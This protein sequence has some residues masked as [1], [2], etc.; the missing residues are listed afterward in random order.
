MVVI[1]EVKPR[2]DFGRRGHRVAG[3]A[4]PQGGVGLAANPTTGHF[5]VSNSAADSLTIFD[6]ASLAELA[7]LPMVGDPGDVA[8][9]PATNRVYV[10]NRGADVVRMIVDNW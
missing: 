10:S 3:E 5:F 2:L 7:T 1:F 9:N 8:V 4:G 6:G